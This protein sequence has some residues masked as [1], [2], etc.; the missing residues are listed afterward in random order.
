M[1]IWGGGQEWG[2][3]FRKPRHKAPKEAVNGRVLVAARLESPRL[4][5]LPGVNRGPCVNGA[6][7]G[8]SQHKL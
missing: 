7:A 3:V 6:G 1:L 8:L 4:L 5:S 2:V